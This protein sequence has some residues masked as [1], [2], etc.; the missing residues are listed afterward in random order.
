MAGSRIRTSNLQRRPRRCA[1]SHRRLCC[2]SEPHTSV[3]GSC[4]P[5]CRNT[6]LL[7][8]RAIQNGATTPTNLLAS[9]RTSCSKATE[10]LAR[11][12]P[13]RFSHEGVSGGAYCHECGF[14]LL[15]PVSDS[16]TQVFSHPAFNQEIPY[17]SDLAPL[18]L[19]GS[20]RLL[21]FQILGCW[22]AREK[23]MTQT[24]TKFCSAT[25]QAEGMKATEALKQ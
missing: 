21:V 9:A 7:T 13:N 4:C 23:P 12:R 8:Q 3:T 2:N 19:K 20:S 11:V 22:H 6:N 15:S 18:V 16:Q 10:H 24:Q 1:E 25:S 14:Q 17:D 5:C